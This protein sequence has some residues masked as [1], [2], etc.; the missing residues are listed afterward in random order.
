MVWLVHNQ[1]GKPSELLSRVLAPQLF[2]I[3]SSLFSFLV[4]TC[5]HWL[6]CRFA[7]ALARSWNRVLEKQHMKQCP[8]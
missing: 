5:S 2:F 4:G 7:P 1:A 8:Y 3:F 6:Y